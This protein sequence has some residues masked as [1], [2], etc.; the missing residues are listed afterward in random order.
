MPEIDWAGVSDADPVSEVSTRI[1]TCS[2][3]CTLLV[4]EE[5]LLVPEEPLLALSEPGVTDDAVPEESASRF[6]I[7]SLLRVAN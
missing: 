3:A 7:R 1:S 4:P 5:P 2:S 6:R